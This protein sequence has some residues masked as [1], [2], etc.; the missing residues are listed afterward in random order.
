MPDTALARKADAIAFDRNA[1]VFALMRDSAAV[2]RAKVRG[3]LLPYRVTD[4][5]RMPRYAA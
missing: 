3:A 5:L 4:R 2:L 1:E